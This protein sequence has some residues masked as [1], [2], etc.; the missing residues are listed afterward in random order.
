MRTIATRIL[1]SVLAALLAVSCGTVRE[2]RQPDIEKRVQYSAFR[3]P[4]G[5]INVGRIHGAP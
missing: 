2:T 1:A 5:S 4:D 3:L